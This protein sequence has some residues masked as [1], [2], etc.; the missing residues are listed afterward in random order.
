MNREFVMIDGSKGIDLASTIH[1]ASLINSVINIGFLWINLYAWLVFDLWL[2]LW[3]HWRYVYLTGYWLLQCIILRFPS[4]CVGILEP[5]KTTKKWK[6]SYDEICLSQSF[7]KINR[8]GGLII[9]RWMGGVV[10][11]IVWVEQSG[12]EQQKMVDEGGRMW[13]TLEWVRVKLKRE[14]VRLER[15]RARLEREWAKLQKSG[16]SLISSLLSSF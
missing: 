9:S 7:T 13:V 3:F 16:E 8:E 4:R 5:A 15:E 12:V 2:V 14:W 11:C 1:K 6:S 10:D